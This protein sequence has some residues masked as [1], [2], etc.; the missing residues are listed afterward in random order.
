MLIE[1]KWIKNKIINI[2]KYWLRELNPNMI[3]LDFNPF[4]KTFNIVSER[5][6]K[7][8]ELEKDGKK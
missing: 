8:S 4:V 5:L 1:S 2:L 6:Q 7:I 3:I